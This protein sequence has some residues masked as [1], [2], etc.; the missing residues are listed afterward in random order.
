[1]SKQ[2]LQSGTKSVSRRGFLAGG[3]TT[4]AALGAMSLAGCGSQRASSAD[5]EGEVRLNYALNEDPQALDPARVNDFGSLELCANIYEGLFRFVGQT[6]EVEPCLAE[7]YELSDDGLT[8][9]F[10]LRQGVKFHDGTDFNA[11]AVV[12]NFERQMNGAGEEDM[13]YAE[14]VFGTDETGT[15]VKSVEATDDY[16]VVCHMRS[17][18][19][20]FVRNL[21]MSLG[22]PI[23][24]P[25]AL[26]ENDG[27]LS[28]APCG[29]GPYK[30]DS[31]DKGSSVT[32]KAFDDYWDTDN[33]PQ[34]STV[35][36][37]V[38]A[39]SSTRV[40]ALSNG[41]VDIITAIE[42]GSA[43]AVEENGDT[44]DAIDGLNVNYLVFNTES[45]KLSSVDLRRAVCQ[46]VNVDEMV[47]ALYGEYA[48]V[49]NSLMPSF[50]ASYVSDIEYPAYDPDAARATFEAA[51]V[52][53]LIAITYTTAMQYNPVGGRVLAESL[54]G[55]L[56]DVGVNLTVNAYDW[57]TFRT[58]RNEEYFDLAFFG[59]AGDNGDP[60]N[61]MNLFADG[62]S[63]ASM[64]HFSNDEYNSLVAQGIATPDGDDRDE[65]YH[66]LEQILSEELPCM[67]LSHA[68]T[69]CGYAPSISGFSMHPTGCSKVASVTK[70]S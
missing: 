31:W 23:A 44:V 18:D 58:K 4:A 5:A 42:Q 63:S 27:N 26:E 41:E 69:V 29:T 21:A 65:I 13:G 22:T 9:T 11:A 30:L 20:P 16:T 36:F 48:T 46:A 7:S 37:H 47:T 14:F 68:K 55:Y 24:S 3:A 52:T 49:A 53:D 62:G 43:P 32:L 17:A 56:S 50:M 45:E 67:P 57:T 34:C 8:Y 15:G 33:S 40:T 54:Q 60:D 28:T 51:G 64:S 2:G 25:T 70:S 12:T 10:H 19:T 35:V 1:M 59:W 39:E 66:R 6:C 38:M 61:F